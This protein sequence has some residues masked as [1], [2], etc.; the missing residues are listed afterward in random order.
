MNPFKPA[1]ALL[2]C[3]LAVPAA[4]GE[5]GLD[6]APSQVSVPAVVAPSAAPLLAEY[7]EYYAALEAYSNKAFALPP[8]S[9]EL[10]DLRSRGLYLRA[11]LEGLDQSLNSL[12]AGEPSLRMRLPGGSAGGKR[13]KTPPAVSGRVAA[14]L[15]AL[16]SGPGFKTQAPPVEIKPGY[17]NITY[18]KG[19]VPYLVQKDGFL[20]KGEVII[21]FDDGPVGETGPFSSSMSAAGAPSVFFMLGS[22]LG[23]AGKAAA[24]Q[25]VA[26]GHELAVHGFYHATEAGKPLTAMSTDLIL[27][28]FGRTA[29][30]LEKLSGGKPALF[31]PPYG[32]ITPE[33]LRALDS[34]LG[35][36]PVGWTLDTLDWSTKDPEELFARTVAMVK[37]R[38]KGIV[39]MHDVHP[40]SREAALRLA[41][42]L[43]ENGY[44]V[45]GGDR[46]A[47][48]YRK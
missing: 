38:G 19:G 29:A 10:Y 42:W 31:R 14:E 30:S 17:C 11:K 34:S 39:L 18:V 37:Q 1:A 24:A 47:A 22:K 6:G 8:D 21:T 26:D 12:A 46:L 36:V 9:P 32:V 20:K 33:A 43:K 23:K 27:E 40:Q 28:H 7:E 3:A 35:L 13:L 41:D 44:K 16:F 2:A 5:F 48:A 15:A 4:A 45:V 25:T